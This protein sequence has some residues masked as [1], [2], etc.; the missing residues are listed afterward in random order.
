MLKQPEKIAVQGTVHKITYHHPDTNYTV[1]R[2]DV[3]NAAGVTVVGGVYPVSEGEEIK[4]TGAW[5]RHPRYGLQ[6]QVEHW[7]KVDPAFTYR[8]DGDFRSSEESVGQN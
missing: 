8:D 3:E 2:L 6:F 4:V 5:K 7:D 1:L